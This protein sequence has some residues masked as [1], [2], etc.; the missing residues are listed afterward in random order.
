MPETA[1]TLADFRRYASLLESMIPADPA[2]VPSAES[3]TSIQVER[4]IVLPRVM[5]E[6]AKG[7]GGVVERLIE[8]TAAGA[9]DRLAVVDGGGH[10]RPVYRPL[11]VYCWLQAFRIVY[12]TL[13]RT[14]FG[15]WEEGLRPWCDL[16]EAELGD[17][18]LA[19]LPA[20]RGGVASEAA[21]TALALYVAGK[22]YVRDAW[23]DLAGVTFGALARGQQ[24][25]GAFLHT[26]AS[27][28]PEPNWYHEL[29]I[30]HACASYAVQAEDRTVAAAV[31]R[32]V[33]HHVAETQPDHATEQ[34]W[35]IF[36]FIWAP[37]ARPLADHLLHL[38]TI[39]QPGGAQGVPLMLL[40]DALY[41][42]RLFL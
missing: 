34:P 25:S 20:T 42:L 30:L 23:T 13:P 28:N 40:A 5:K 7:D 17:M 41:C 19:N 32:A 12:E 18:A 33:A 16:L 14:Q 38:M 35:G 36:P 31:A 39:S 2:F 3:A 24:P 1:T 21:W 11:L 22:V 15:R 9:I 4:G 37:S 10:H 6:P 27:D 8:V 29:T 26:S